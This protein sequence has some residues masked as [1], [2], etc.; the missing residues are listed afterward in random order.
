MARRS[1][2]KILSRDARKLFRYDPE[3]G[4]LY[5][6]ESHGSAK[7]GSRVGC[8]HTDGNR[9]LVVDGHTMQE[10]AIVYLIEHGRW[11]SKGLFHVNRDKSDNRITNL[12]NGSEEVGAMR[13]ELWGNPDELMAET[14]LPAAKAAL[15]W[16]LCP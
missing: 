5:W 15:L 8:I 2:Q 4:A 9:R 3:L 16:L 14:P 12:A 6:S 11:P 7:A 13:F 10:G 1:N